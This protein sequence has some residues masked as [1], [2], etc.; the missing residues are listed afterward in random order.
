MVVPKTPHHNRGHFQ[1][2][3]TFVD[4]PSDRTPHGTDS[5]RLLIPDDVAVDA[6]DTLY[7]MPVNYSA[8]FDRHNRRQ[9]AGVITRA[10]LDDDKVM[11]QGFLY[12]DDLGDVWKR[13]QDESHMFGFS[14][15][16]ARTQYQKDGD[17][18]IVNSIEFTGA[19]LMLA[20][21]A[22]YQ[23]TRIFLQED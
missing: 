9:K 21:H 23:N 16:S 8:N 22:A 19:T 13:L 15:D 7:G 3:L 11:I 4:V 10:W 1:G 14:F 2:I 6:L 20:R 12:K 17:I 18:Y 5:H